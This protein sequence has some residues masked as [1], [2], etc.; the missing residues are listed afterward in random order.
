MPKKENLPRVLRTEVLL[1][2]AQWEL[3][4]PH[5]VANTYVTR[6]EN[7][8]LFVRF[9][10]NVGKM[11]LRRG[12]IKN[13]PSNALLN[14][15]TLKPIVQKNDKGEWAV[16]LEEGKYSAWFGF[17]WKQQITNEELKEYYECRNEAE[18][19]LI[20]LLKQ[21]QEKKRS[22]NTQPAYSAPSLQCKIAQ[23]K[24]SRFRCTPLCLAA[25]IFIAIFI[26]YSF[27]D[28]PEPQWSEFSVEE[29]T[30]QLKE[31]R[32]SQ[33]DLP[34]YEPEIVDIEI[35]LESRR[36]K[37]AEMRD[38]MFAQI[39]PPDNLIIRLRHKAMAQSSP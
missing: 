4:A 25:A 12:D 36:K 20:S 15:D 34:F 3:Y 35:V 2:L 17:V 26:P 27:I 5:E 22:T 18:Q 8:D 30:A 24:K 19:G 37:E 31:N 33:K 21:I 39:Q 29:Y 9:R 16:V 23:Q 10:D 7:P 6:E 1:R 11:A 13:E 38:L 28:E 32:L 14:P